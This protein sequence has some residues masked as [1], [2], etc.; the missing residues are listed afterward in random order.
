L[1]ALL[2][3]PDVPATEA[4]R[5]RIVLWH[6]EQRPKKEIAGLL[7]RGNFGQTNTDSNTPCRQTRDALRMRCVA[8]DTKGRFDVRTMFRARTEEARLADS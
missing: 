8:V 4:T 2:N 6:A 1:R 7:A 5:A 3:S